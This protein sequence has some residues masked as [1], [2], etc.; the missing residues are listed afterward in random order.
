MSSF[1]L[2]KWVG[3]PPRLKADGYSVANWKYENRRAFPVNLPPSHNG[4]T[5]RVLPKGMNGLSET[6]TWDR[7]CEAWTI[8]VKTEDAAIILRVAS[9]EF[10]DVTNVVDPSKVRNDPIISGSR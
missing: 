2:I 5:T 1:R 4:G 9:S 8:P 3:H 6:Y 10:R 7:K